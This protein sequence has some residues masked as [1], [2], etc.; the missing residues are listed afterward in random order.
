[1]KEI[2][3]WLSDIALALST[4]TWSAADNDVADVSLLRVS[5]DVGG[6]DSV[7]GA[8]L[9]VS[10]VSVSEMH[11]VTIWVRPQISLTYNNKKTVWCSWCSARDFSIG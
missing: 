6:T 3:D 1:M 8:E 10:L 4:S 11:A 2:D 9:F 5:T 7:A